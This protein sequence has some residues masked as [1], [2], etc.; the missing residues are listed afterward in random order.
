VDRGRSKTNELAADEL[1]ALLAEE[2]HEL[3]SSTVRLEAD[4]LDA[5]LAQ[6]RPALPSAPESRP[7]LA[8]QPYDAVTAY[9][10]LDKDLQPSDLQIDTHEEDADLDMEPDEAV[11]EVTPDAILV[12]PRA[13]AIAPA[14]EPPALAKPPSTRPA[15]PIPIPLPPPSAARAS[16]PSVTMEW[17]GAKDRKRRAISFVA[18]GA[19]LVAIALLYFS[20]AE[21]DPLL[22]PAPASTA[23][24][25]ALAPSPPAAQSPSP[26]E[27]DAR[28]ALVRLREGIGDCVRHAIGSLPGSSPA[29]PAGL[30]L[31]AGAGYTAAA[32]DWKT[33]VW[34]CARFRHDSPMRF[35][36]QWQSVKPGTEALG[37]AWIDDDGD[38][39][40]DRALG[41]RATAKGARDVDL[42]E[43]APM[44]MRPI[45][46]IR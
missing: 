29:V 44:E 6:S 34:S 45:L 32:A 9:A 35:Q 43:V 33:A 23:E 2:D 27:V 13:A 4:E 40:A 39:D 3:G 22:A 19:A 41:F 31:T 24:S 21:P 42:G 18:I 25:V 7:L 30:K 12:A 10:L 16:L 14:P 28:V 8:T 36:L 15:A 1:A 20:L 5:L 26:A 38:G 46:S 11:V 17:P 37:I